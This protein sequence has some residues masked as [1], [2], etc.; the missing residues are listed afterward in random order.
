MSRIQNQSGQQVAAEVLTITH[1]F[2]APRDLVFKAWTEPERVKRWWG[3]KNFT[4]TDCRIDLRVGGVFFNCIRSPDGKEYCSQGVYRAIEEP[5]RIVST[6]T[7]ADSEGHPVPPE[8]YGMSSDWPEEAVIEV[9]FTEYSGKTTVNIR[10]APLPQG[11]E[12]DMCEQGWNESMERLADYLAGASRQPSEETLTQIEQKVMHAVAIDEFGGI[13]KM[14]LR[15]I[16][17]PEVGPGEIL[18]RVESAGVGVWDPFEREGGFARLFGTESEFPY[19]LGS[20]GAGTVAAVGE[21]VSRFKEGDRVYAIGVLNR[22]GGFYAEYT[23]VKEDNASLIPDNLT[24]EQAGAM[25]VDA[26]TAL[27]GLDKLDLKPRESLMV[28]GASGGVGHLAVQL[29]KRIGARV[30][31]VASGTDGV[32]LAEELGADSAVDGR[33]DDVAAAALRFAPKGIDAALITAGGEAAEQALMAMRQGGRVAYPNGVDPEPKVRAGVKVESY[34]GMPDPQTI[35]RLSRLIESGPFTVHIARMFSLD[36]AAEAHRM[37]E[38]H[39][40]GKLALR[41]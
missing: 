8:Q 4:C 28:F 23:A 19:V 15:T 29:A 27:C 14:K 41:P 18:I 31:A 25:P 22:K 2:D 39:Y 34:D 13:E 11:R 16:P 7:F 26:I 3:P 9:N 30:L 17:I 32:S 35:E 10:H 36:E 12:R 5:Q 37:L 21:H 1:V 6:D 38:E 20:D 33:K 24:T 40:L